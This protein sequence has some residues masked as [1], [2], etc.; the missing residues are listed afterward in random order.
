MTPARAAL[1]IA[2][3]ASALLA[4]SRDVLE[5][6]ARAQSSSS[7]APKPAELPVASASAS[8]AVVLP[9]LDAGLDDASADAAIDAGPAN[10]CPP[11]MARVG[12]FCI[13]RWEA[14]LVTR[15]GTPHPH[16]ERPV[17][18]LVARSEADVFPQGYISRLEAAAAC[19]AAGKRLCSLGEWQRTCRGKKGKLYPYGFSGKNGVCNTGKKHLLTE[20]F[21]SNGRAWKYDENFNSPELLKTEGY[22][23]KTGAYEGCASEDGVMDLVGNLHEWVSDSVDEGFVERMESEP[24]ER[25]KQPWREGNGIFASGFFSTTKEHGPGCTFLTIAHEPSYHDYSIGFR[26]CQTAKP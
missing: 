20:L 26:C 13:D 22:L 7:S 14:H 3:V 18:G 5:P 10:G 9:V 11:E 1:A 4:C 25:R 6:Q 17:P 12:R 19:S 8:A 23:A 21:G 24:V 16:Y 15:T 2:L